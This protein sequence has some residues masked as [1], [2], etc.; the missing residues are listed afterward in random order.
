[1]NSVLSNLI[2]IIMRIALR[3]KNFPISFF[4]PALGLAGFTLA[5]IKAEK[6]LSIPHNLTLSVL[7]FTIFVFILVS[8]IYLLKV[9]LY[10]SDVKKEFNHPVKIN[11]FPLI[12]KVLLVL[13]VVFLSLNMTVSYW[14]WIVG[15]VISTIFSFKILS[16]W[17]AKDHFHI[18]HL[19]PAWFIPVVGNIIIP[20]AGIQHVNP[21]IS[22]FFFTVGFV[23]MMI[24]SIIIFYRLIFYDPLP[25]KLLPTFFIIFA[26]PAI[27]FIAYYKLSSSFDAFARIL[28]YYSLFIF[29]LTAVQW[30]M[31]TK[32][33]FYLSWWAYTFP[34][35]AFFLA[36]VLMFHITKLIA[37][38]WLAVL[39]IALLTLFIAYLTVRTLKAI[40]Q[41][42]ICIEDTP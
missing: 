11:F 8:F 23:W 14:L 30:R 39:I 25:G 9:F 29:L 31:F 17:I 42:K 36:T 35:A 34:L 3:L 26:A 10:L 21:E 13:S 1:V 18:K 2:F 22:W 7:I 12:S 5:L 27:A 16:T 41:Y 15:V 19:S 38:K 24:L 40:L 37:F 20:I 4:A 33:K 32:I 28:Y 6:L